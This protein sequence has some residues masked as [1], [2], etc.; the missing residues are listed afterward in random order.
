[1]DALLSQESV[2]GQMFR[3]HLLVPVAEPGI[4]HEFSALVC[5]PTADSQPIHP[6]ASYTPDDLA[7]L[8]TVFVA[9]QDVAEDMGATVFLPGSHQAHVHADL[10]SADADVKNQMLASAEYRKSTLKAGDVAIMDARTLHFGSANTS[11]DRRVLL[12]FT[13]RNPAHGDTDK[14]FPGCGSLFP[15]LHMTTTDFW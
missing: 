12:Y 15:G 10:N 3:D 14:D 11:C 2:I 7:P 6:D 1:L 8:W 4:F 13:I 5:D 9:L